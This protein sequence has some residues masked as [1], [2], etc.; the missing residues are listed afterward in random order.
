MNKKLIAALVCAVIV[1]AAI[2]YLKPA[3]GPEGKP[4]LVVL[5]MTGAAASWG[6]HFQRGVTMFADEYS[7]GSLDVVVIDS[8]TDPAKALLGVQQACARSEPYGI[9]STLSTITAPLVEWASDENRFVVCCMTSDAVL[10]HPDHI[11]RIYPSADDNARPPAEFA[12][13]QY[14]TIAVLYGKGE[15]GESVNRIF[16]RHY[17]SDSTDIV[18]SEVYDA[19]DASIARSLAAK[20][21]AAQPDAVFINGIGA[22]YW[23]LFR[24]LR[25][26]GFEGAMISDASFGDLSQIK[27]LG[28]AAESV[29]F[30]AGETELSEPR[31][32]AA[33]EFS[34]KFKAKFSEPPN[35]TGI[36][37]FESLRILQE[38]RKS[39][40]LATPAAFRALGEWQSV[41]G[42]IQML[43]DGDCDYPWI[44]VQYKDG[45]ILP[46]R[47][48]NGA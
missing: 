30:M 45:E 28:G 6:E 8:Q 36:T 2:V 9:V 19:S 44:L 40:D 48:D 24:E 21:H 13:R 34:E 25:T 29:V 14:P 27:R 41:A 47:D 33:R 39:H 7:D 5:P 42:P 38:I 22:G 23:A 3:D 26:I 16:A 20:V 15:F 43:P 11:Q 46:L 12:R 10:E 18:V 37:V 32:K 35:Y 31:T 17:K 4:V 1:I